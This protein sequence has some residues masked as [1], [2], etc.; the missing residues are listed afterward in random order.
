VCKCPKKSQGVQSQLAS[1]WKSPL[2]A[3]SDAFRKRAFLGVS[4]WMR[5]R[6]EEEEEEPCSLKLVSAEGM[7]T[8]SLPWL[9]LYPSVIYFSRPYCIKSY[10]APK[11]TYSSGD[12]SLP[13]HTKRS[14]HQAFAVLT[15][16]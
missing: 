8:S 14:D 11:T 12:S 3:Q 4:S 1:F 9:A 15:K 13:K 6:L 16:R 10:Q 7:L 5:Q 2:R